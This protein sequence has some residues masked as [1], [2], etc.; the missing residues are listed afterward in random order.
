MSTSFSFLL[1]YFILRPFLQSPSY[2]KVHCE[3]TNQEVLKKLLKAAGFSLSFPVLIL[4]PWC[5]TRAKQ[6]TSNGVKSPHFS[7][8]RPPAKKILSS[9][10]E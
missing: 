9:Q 10:K 8:G 2:K 3:K 6:T 1:T 4:R 7:P 5:S